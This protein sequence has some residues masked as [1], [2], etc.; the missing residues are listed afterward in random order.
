MQVY[1][2]IFKRFHERDLTGKVS[3]NTVLYLRSKIQVIVEADEDREYFTKTPKQASVTTA[4][5]P[6][7]LLNGII[8]R[9]SGP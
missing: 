8:S 7:A 4:L 1:F 3:V 5:V 9:C 2:Y 6:E